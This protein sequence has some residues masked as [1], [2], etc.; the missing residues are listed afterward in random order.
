MIE[1]AEF[2]TEK[3]W[4]KK[5]QIEILIDGLLMFMLLKLVADILARVLICCVW[6]GTVAYF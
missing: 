1:A 4:N 5:H 2:F 3:T 6:N